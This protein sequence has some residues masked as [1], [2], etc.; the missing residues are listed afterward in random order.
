MFS[1]SV[2]ASVGRGIVLLVPRYPSTCSLHVFA[3]CQDLVSYGNELCPCT[4]YIQF[5]GVLWHRRMSRLWLLC[6]GSDSPGRDYAAGLNPLHLFRNPPQQ[7]YESWHVY[8]KMDEPTSCVV[9]FPLGF[10]YNARLEKKTCKLLKS[11]PVCVHPLGLVSLS[12]GIHVHACR[13][14]MM[15]AK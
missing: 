8:H 9:F 11:D 4:R 7:G 14:H 10:T 2:A 15:I 13:P 3:P 12:L 6:F 1:N 5:N